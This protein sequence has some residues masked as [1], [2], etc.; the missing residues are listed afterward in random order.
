MV[1]LIDNNFERHDIKDIAIDDSQ[2]LTKIEVPYKFPCKFVLLNLDYG[3]AINLFDK[4]TMANLQNDLNKIKDDTA[5]FDIQNQLMYN[6][7]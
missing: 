4:T 5:R 7:K 2:K 1:S 3:Y 6:M